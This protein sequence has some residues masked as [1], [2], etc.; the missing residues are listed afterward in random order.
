MT[1][2][3]QRPLKDSSLFIPVPEAEHLVGSWRDTYD[4]TT[5]V[6]FP[7]HITL[8]YPFLPPAEITAEVDAELRELF[9]SVP[10]FS[11]TL[12]GVCGFRGL[13]WLAPEPRE[14]YLQLTAE[15]RRRY[16]HLAPYGDPNRGIVAPHLTVAR[17]A[18]I[19]FLHAVTKT[20]SDGLPLSALARD[21]WLLA[22]DTP[23]WTLRS[24]YTL[25]SSEAA[26][27]DQQHATRRTTPAPAPPPGSP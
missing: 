1:G 9:A 20:L 25:G 6:G 12:N 11:F 4:R 18:D 7:A 21:V 15:L 27:S 3:P 13:V 22:E 24:L 2:L 14:P 23:R 16:P 10:E 5:P 17:S 26:T 8:L 19:E